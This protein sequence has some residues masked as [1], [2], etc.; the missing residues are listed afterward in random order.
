MYSKSGFIFVL[1]LAFFLSCSVQAQEL[2]SLA[3]DSEKFYQFISGT[4]LNTPSKATAEKSQVL[5]DRFNQRWSI[6]RFNKQEKDEVRKVIESM[7]KKNLKTY[8]YLYDYIYA[9]T[10]LAESNQLPKSIIAWH[11]YADSLIQNPKIKYFSDF[12]DFTIDFLE[13]DRLIK[14]NYSWYH[15]NSQFIF[16]F[17]TGF[18]VKFESLTLVCSSVKDSSSIIKTKGIYYYKNNT[19]D[20]KGGTVNWNR[21]GKE[22]GDEIYVDLADYEINL[23]QATYS[24]DSAVL[25]YKRFFKNPVLGRFTDKVM[26]SPPNERSSYPRFE[27]YL[28][29]FELENIYPFITYFGGF[30]LNGIELFGNS[31]PYDISR[32]II[33]KNNKIVGRAKSDLFKLGDKQLESGKAEVVFYIESDSLYHPGVRFRYKAESHDLQ[34]FSEVQG[35]KIVPF[36]DSY[37]QFDIYSPALTWNLDSLNMYFKEIMAVNRESEATLLSVN[38]FSAND[39]YTIQGLN[40][41]NPMYSIQNYLNIYND[42]EIK[43]NALAAYMKKSTEQVSAVLINLAYDG[44]LIYDPVKQTAIVKDR[45]Y[46]FLTA[47]SGRTDYDVIKLVSRVKNKPNAL[48]NLKDLR[49]D[50]FG[51]REVVLSDSQQVY[52][53]PTDQKISIRKNRNITFDGRIH[54]GLFDFYSRN[55]TFIYD[56]FMINM[57]YIDSLSFKVYTLDSL[58]RRDSLIRVQNIVRD[59]NGR[60]YIDQPFNK[61]GLKNFPEFPMFISNEDS[62]VFY[63]YRDI[64][65]STL[66]PETFYFKLDPFKLDSI[67]TYSTEGMEFDGTMVSAGIFPNFRQPLKVMPDF[68]LGF[69]HNTPAEGYPVY[70]GKGTFSD[71]IFINKN[72]ISG[73]GLLNYLS[74]T[75]SSNNFIFYPDSLVSTSKNFQIAES[76]DVYNFPFAQGDTVDIKWLIDTNVMAISNREKPF[77]LYKDSWLQGMLYLNP[78]YLHGD[79]SFHFSKSEIQ[80]ANIDF[81]YNDLVADS[82]KFFLRKDVDTLVFKSLGYLA[83]IDFAQQKG[84]FDH[85]YDNSFVEFPYNKFTSN[86]DEAEW[87]MTEDKIYLL[88]DLSGAYSALDTLDPYSLIDY[89]LSGPEFIS[90]DPNPDSVIRFFAGKATYDLNNFTIDVE[91]VRMVKAADAAIFPSNEFL[92][93]LRDG[94]IHT[95]KNARIILDT[96]TKYHEIIDAQV[97]ILNKQRYV[98]SG[99]VNYV[100]RNMTKQSVFIQRITQN[101]EGVSTGLGVLEPTD[102]FFLSP[103]Y[104]FTGEISFFA[105]KKFLFFSGG[106]RI[107]EDCIGQEGKWVSFAKFIDPDSIYFEINEKSMIVDQG[108][109][110]FGIAYSEETAKYYPLVLAPLKNPQDEILIEARGNIAFDAEN[111]SYFVMQGGLSKKEVSE[112]NFVSLNLDRCLLEGNGM[113]PLGVSSNVFGV[114]AGGSFRHLIIPDSTY[115]NVSLLLNFFFDQKAFS[116]ITDSIRIANTNLKK[117]GLGQFPLFVSKLLTAS[118]S[119]KLNTELNL[120]G[121]VKKMP[122]QLNHAIIFSDVKFKWDVESRSFI[123]QGP[124]GIGFI[125]GQSINKYV[126]GYIQIEKNRGGSSI[127]FYL[128][129]NKS[130]WYFFTYRNGILQFISSD[131]TLN[132]YIET[133]PASARIINA[134][135]LENYFEFVIST[136]NKSVE[137]LRKMDEIERK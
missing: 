1:L 11:M 55:N 88:S 91:Q 68:S 137:F 124:I 87:D 8:P 51:V 65:D 100:D 79:G 105:N 69:E 126:N 25:H 111:N 41:L 20:G 50:L 12:L 118:E 28:K 104:F 10:L 86:L 94:G 18:I 76:P 116:I 134:N 119:E 74:A 4:L 121:Q 24:A 98:A 37:H 45:F 21:F 23:S 85:I 81:R 52:I 122:D 34:L 80:S 114:Q 125:N 49:L 107:N 47:K 110:R 32:I 5:L 40:E 43:L 44:F 101:A 103:E 117:T 48:I 93:I 27:S 72:G 82:A 90:T 42:K 39:F 83:K 26:S 2:D 61:S 77:T 73:S 63:N 7:R 115:L 96:L 54:M 31:G 89:K 75:V 14:N 58:M 16:T 6:G 84:W 108:N 133:L 92:K 56:T 135:S 29:N 3:G 17:D 97:D 15:R 66:L 19:W 59:L 33:E 46:S 71:T 13:S 113:F 38:Y 120:Y 70:G 112:G 131:Y 36:F 22:M 9:L 95:L 30:Y 128:K 60:I 99:Y 129:L 57:N 130:Q 78:G 102:V 67:G 123:S 127:S 136:R 53:Y 109:A 106:Y 132:D 64:Q 35:T 62:Y